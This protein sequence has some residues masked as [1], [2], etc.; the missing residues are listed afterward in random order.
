MKY[1]PV[2]L[3]RELVRIDSRNPSL[4]ADGPGEIACARALRDVLDSWGFRTDIL[5]NTPRRASVVARIGGGSG[6]SLILNGHIDTVQVDGMTHAP[7]A[8][9]IKDGK[10]W[11]RGSCDMKGG[12]AA[13]CAAAARAHAAGTLGGEVVIAAVSDE[14]WSSIGTRD[15]LARGI[16]ADAVIVTEPTRMAV[17]TAH[18]GF[19]WFTIN[20]RGRAAHGSR[21]DIGIDAIRHAGFLLAELDAH[22]AR[23]LTRIT[24][25][26]LGHASFHAGLIQGGEAMT[27]YP[28]KCMLRIE[29]R[30]LPGE[31]PDDIHAQIQAACDAV[32]A[33]VP[34]FNATVEREVYRAPSDVPT[35]APIVN[36][37]LDATEK[38]D[39]ARAKI[40]GVSYW[41]DA[42]LFNAAGMHA[43]CFGPGD[44]AL[45]HG[46]VE[47]IPVDEITRATAVLEQ[48]L[49][50]WTN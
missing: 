14:E 5:E 8:A 44:I 49:A 6:R 40:E 46:A 12:V 19:V 10:I 35:D 33:R 25:P 31:S 50:Q 7:Y 47:W 27:A 23:D 28:E 15:V 16:R 30:S 1:D 36:A 39:G 4:A 48:V 45:A 13:M 41:A 22:E 18:R 29:R 17:A 20:F 24:H 3:T 2:E 37:L 11:G 32:K 34:S 21:Y 43:V 26:L 42:A 9:E 38:A